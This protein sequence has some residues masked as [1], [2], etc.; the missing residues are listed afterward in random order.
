MCENNDL[1]GFIEQ[2]FANWNFSRVLDN[3]SNLGTNNP[4][5]YYIRFEIPERSIVERF[6][7]TYFLCQDGSIRLSE[8]LENIIDDVLFLGSRE[9]CAEICNA[10]ENFFEEI[11]NTAGLQKNLHYFSSNIVRNPNIPPRNLFTRDEISAVIG[12]GNDNFD[13]RLV[14]D[15]NG[16]PFLLQS[17]TF[18]VETLYPVRFEIWGSGNDY[19]G[20]GATQDTEFINEV[21]TSA[22]EYW[23]A[24]LQS[25]R[26]QYIDL[27]SGP[28]NEEE[29]IEE[30]R[31][32]M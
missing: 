17:P 20:N 32:F 2:N 31:S 16:V 23:L 8:R 10:C 7:T 9:E 27:F 1:R 13:N 30:I 19:V 14:I 26:P 11:V 25:G 24:Y 5:R 6:N 4:C 21:Y 12:L 28:I 22:L 18:P 29:I 15:E 3:I